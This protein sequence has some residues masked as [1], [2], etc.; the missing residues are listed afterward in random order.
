MH[1]AS[2]TVQ[3][4]E[5]LAADSDGKALLERVYEWFVVI[6]MCLCV[7]VFVQSPSN[8]FAFSLS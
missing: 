7:C 5:S 4:A 1:E 8:S 6:E 3:L 2:E